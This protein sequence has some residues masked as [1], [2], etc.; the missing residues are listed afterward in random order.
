MIN[1][2]R[3]LIF[4]SLFMVASCLRIDASHT[5]NWNVVDVTSA[6]LGGGI[7]EVTATI[8]FC[9]GWCTGTAISCC[10]GLHDVYYRITQVSGGC[11]TC[12]SGAPIVIGPIDAG[13]VGPPY[14]ATN[15]VLPTCPASL[16]DPGNV[17]IS[18]M[19]IG[20]PGEQ[21]LLEVFAVNRTT[22]ARCGGIGN[23]PNVCTNGCQ[24]SP[25]TQWLVADGPDTPNGII[26]VPGTP[27]AP[28]LIIDPSDL[29]FNLNCGD[30]AFNFGVPYDT[31]VCRDEPGTSISYDFNLVTNPGSCL[32]ILTADQNIVT[33]CGGTTAMN[34]FAGVLELQHPSFDDMCGGTAP[35]GLA[36]GSNIFQ[37]EITVTDNCTSL[38]T[39][40]TFDVEIILGPVP[41]LCF[42]YM[43]DCEGQGEDEMIAY[44]GPF[45]QPAGMFTMSPSGPAA[46]ILSLV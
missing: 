2:T 28:E 5:M 44:P 11:A 41:A 12:P 14:S 3:K 30:P 38:S 24:S 16:G 26:T 43:D 18:V 6:T 9:N 13:F 17:E 33:P 29:V 8:G 37:V 22:L 23:I 46:S 20:C 21:Y 27:S 1:T 39:T 7:V 45:G 36:P 40:E 31:D 42:D 15:P 19:V 35:C 10:G 34:P 32:N 4:L 25:F